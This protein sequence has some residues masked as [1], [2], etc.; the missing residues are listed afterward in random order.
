MWAVASLKSAM[1]P[2]PLAWECY[3]EYKRE[4]RPKMLHL[5]PGGFLKGK[6]D[7]RAPQTVREAGEQEGKAAKSHWWVSVLLA[8]NGEEG[9]TGRSEVS[10][11]VLAET[12]KWIF[13]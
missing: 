7:L 4:S 6:C 1:L 11:W 8:L 2:H 10:L 9:A 5:N 12:R 3:L 13:P